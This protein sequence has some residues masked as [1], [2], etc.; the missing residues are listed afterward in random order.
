MSQD[1]ALPPRRAAPLAGA[2]AHAI[3]A[4]LDDSTRGVPHADD[5]TQLFLHRQEE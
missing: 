2:A 1:A 5:R 4:A 3:E